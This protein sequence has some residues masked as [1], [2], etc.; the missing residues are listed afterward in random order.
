MSRA[1]DT[2]SFLF[3]DLRDY[4][5]FVERHGDVAATELIADY[6]RLVRAEVARTGGGEVKTEGDSFYIVF[7][8]A[9]QAVECAVG[10]LRSAEGTASTARPIRVGVGLHAGEPVPHEGQFVGSAVNIAARLAQ[11]AGAGELLVSE[12]IRGLLRTS[13]APPMEERTG[14]TL[15]GISDPPRV[16]AVSWR[17]VV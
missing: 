16:Y 14:M 2:R 1:L 4:T 9:R 15:K 17:S 7:T 10:M 6:R 13:G 5:S 3:A 8:S 11:N 12:V